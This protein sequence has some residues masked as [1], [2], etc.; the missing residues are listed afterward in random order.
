[1][2][3]WQG[4][5][6]LIKT[7]V[8]SLA[9]AVNPLGGIDVNIQDQTTPPIFVKANQVKGATTL[10]SNIVANGTNRV[11]EVAS[12]AGI[13]LGNYVGVFSLTTGRFYAG[14]IVALS[15]TTLTMDNPFDSDFVI[16]EIVG[17]GI[18]NMIL[19]GSVTPQ[20]V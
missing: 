7:A 15:G 9:T 3:L 19:D 13:S 18:T 1:M 8:Q 4:V 16:G 5:H 11:M 17:F 10:A 20:V 12:A 2:S 6:G 14:V